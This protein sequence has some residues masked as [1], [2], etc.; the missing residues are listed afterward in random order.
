M[1]NKPKAKRSQEEVL[2][3][4]AS[5]VAATIN[6]A[7]MGLTDEQIDVEQFKKIF[8]EKVAEMLERQ[9]MLVLSIGPCINTGC[10]DIYSNDMRSILDSIESIMHTKFYFFYGI[11]LLVGKNDLFAN[12]LPH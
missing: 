6:S 10:T 3:Q 5:L 9:E 2:T 8:K 1:A 11:L 12:W 4:A 7:A